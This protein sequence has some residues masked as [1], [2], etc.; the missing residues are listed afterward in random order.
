MNHFQKTSKKLERLR[1]S[2]FLTGLIIAGGL[3]LLAF[4]WTSSASL[5]ILPEPKDR[6][7]SEEWEIPPIIFSESAKK[8][9]VK[10]TQPKIDPN[11]FEIIDNDTPVESEEEPQEEENPALTFNDKEWKTVDTDPLPIEEPVLIPGKYPYYEDCEAINEDERKQCTEEKMYRHF[12]KITKIPET[13]KMRG[14]AEYKAFVYFEVNKKGKIVNVKILND[15]NHPIPKELQREAYN[16]VASLPELIP[17]KN[18]GKTVSVIYK[19]PI[20][21]TVK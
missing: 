4:E 14:A 15:E 3:T 18:H 16:A 6:F 17:G 2:F 12:S 20:K 7:E 8:P 11:Q 10:I 5:T 9:E 13:I 21:F 1:G 19:A